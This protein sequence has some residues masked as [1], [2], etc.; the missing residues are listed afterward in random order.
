MPRQDYCHAGE[1]WNFGVTDDEA[2]D[3]ETTGGE[4]TGDAGEDA[5]LILHKAIQNVSFWRAGRWEGGFVKDGGDGGWGCEGGRGG[6]GKRRSA[7]V[8]GF[9]SYC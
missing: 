2:V 5:R 9:V 4:D 3:V 7:A 8:D 6:G 1:V